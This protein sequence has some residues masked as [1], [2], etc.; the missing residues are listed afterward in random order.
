MRGREGGKK[1]D[2]EGKIGKKKK[3]KATREARTYAHAEMAKKDVHRIKGKG[4]MKEEP[5]VDYIFLTFPFWVY[6]CENHT[7]KVPFLPLYWDKNEINQIQFC[8]TGNLV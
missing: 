5:V 6:F 8:M 1:A 2:R 3:K 7:R 4:K